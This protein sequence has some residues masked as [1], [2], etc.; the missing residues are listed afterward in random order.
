[1][2]W[3]IVPAYPKAETPIA[4]KTL[5]KSCG[6]D[7]VGTSVVSSALESRSLRR[8]LSWRSCAL[9]THIW[10]PIEHAD[11]TIP[12]KPE[13][14]SVCPT[15][16]LIAPITCGRVRAACEDAT[17]APTSVGSPRAVPVPCAST[18]IAEYAS[19]PERSCTARNRLRCASPFGAVKLALRPSCRTAEPETQ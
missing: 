7:C 2:A 19:D 4:R 14:G 16:A 10:T 3:A 9:P 13:T 12:T 6:N 18:P 1:M 11:L 17:R 15:F 8:G 5:S